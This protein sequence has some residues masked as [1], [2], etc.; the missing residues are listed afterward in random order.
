MTQRVGKTNVLRTTLQT[1]FETGQIKS[2]LVISHHGGHI[3][4]ESAADVRFVGGPIIEG[5]IHGAQTEIR[6]GNQIRQS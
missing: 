3:Y 2:A 4:C 6:E 1:L 5:E